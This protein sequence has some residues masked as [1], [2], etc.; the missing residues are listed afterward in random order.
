MNCL[1]CGKNVEGF[2]KGDHSWWDCEHC[3]VRWA[4]GASHM[5]SIVEERGYDGWWIDFRRV[6]RWVPAGYLL[7][8]AWEEEA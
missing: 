3:G 2:D 6:Q 7:V 4:F 1:R 8:L 5:A